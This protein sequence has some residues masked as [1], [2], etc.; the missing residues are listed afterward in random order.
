MNKVS[1]SKIWFSLGRYLLKK[2]AIAINIVKS[3]FEEGI[4][5]KLKLATAGQG[6]LIL[7]INWQGNINPKNQIQT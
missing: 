1:N 4:L 2:M 6:T 5:Q 3:F 7:Q